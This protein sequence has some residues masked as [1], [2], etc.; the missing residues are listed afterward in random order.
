MYFPIFI[1]GVTNQVMLLLI[2][3]KRLLGSVHLL[4]LKIY[5]ILGGHLEQAQLYSA[6]LLLIQTFMCVCVC[7]C[8]FLQPQ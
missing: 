7:V 4:S 2:D 8:I 3:H 5:I 6:F 1:S